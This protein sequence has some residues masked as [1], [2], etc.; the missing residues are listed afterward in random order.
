M[1]AK[2]IFVLFIPSVGHEAYI[3]TEQHLRDK[4]TDYHVLIICTDNVEYKV[5]V[6]NPSEIEPVTIEE[7]KALI[8]A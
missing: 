8:T 2:P 7:I 5:Q 6:F 4:L 1:N 3:H